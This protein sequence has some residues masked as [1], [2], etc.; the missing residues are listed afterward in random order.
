MP[1]LWA[2]QTC[3]PRSEMNPKE[4]P[5]PQS[6]Q[7]SK[8]PKEAPKRSPRRLKTVSKR[9]PKDLPRDPSEHSTAL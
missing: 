2:F 9:P 3:T 7:A 6:T 4:A 1:A 5:R 8:R